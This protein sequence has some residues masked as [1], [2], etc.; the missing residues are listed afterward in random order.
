MFYSNYLFLTVGKDT[1]NGLNMKKIVLE[2]SK[3]QL[4]EIELQNHQESITE[5]NVETTVINIELDSPP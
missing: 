4:L 1:G 2:E 3:E 5:D